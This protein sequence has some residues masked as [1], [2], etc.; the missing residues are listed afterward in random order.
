MCFRWLEIMIETLLRLAVDGRGK[1]FA[2]PD[3]FRRH[4]RP[5][6]DFLRGGG[7]QLCRFVEEREAELGMVEQKAHGGGEVLI[8]DFVLDDKGRAAHFRGDFPFQDEILGVKPAVAHFARDDVFAFV[9]V[10]VFGHAHFFRRDVAHFAVELVFFAVQLAGAADV[11]QAAGGERAG[12]E[13]AGEAV[14]VDFREIGRV[15]DAGFGKIR[16]GDAP[17]DRGRH[18]EAAGRQNLEAEDAGVDADRLRSRRAAAVVGVFPD[19]RDLADRACALEKFRPGI[20]FSEHVRH[21]AVSLSLKNMNR[22]ARSA[23][24][25]II[26]AKANP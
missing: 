21:G 13:V 7:E 2:V 5:R 22:A 4:A 3:L 18:V 6:L 24:R 10:P 16:A 8:L 14:R 12:E 26:L 1:A 25:T 20:G 9:A 23:G 17:V 15:A 19:A 11:V